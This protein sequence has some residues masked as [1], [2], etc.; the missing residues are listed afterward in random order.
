[1]FEMHNIEE[2]ERN[3]NVKRYA[4]LESEGRYLND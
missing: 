2:Y 1:M 3:V 4:L